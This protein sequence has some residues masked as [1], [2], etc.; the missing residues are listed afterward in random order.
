MSV[1]RTCGFVL[2][3]LDK[4]RFIFPSSWLKW[5]IEL[6]FPRAYSYTECLQNQIQGENKLAGFILNTFPAWYSQDTKFGCQKK[7][8]TIAFMK[9]GLPSPL[10]PSAR[11][12]FYPIFLQRTNFSQLPHWEKNVIYLPHG[13]RN[14]PGYRWGRSDACGTGAPSSHF[15]GSWLWWPQAGKAGKRSP[16]FFHADNQA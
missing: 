16:T 5:M 11:I 12:F 9:A 13:S 15:P 2:H 1:S 8:H 14:L 6:G 3:N 10:F 4:Q 7:P